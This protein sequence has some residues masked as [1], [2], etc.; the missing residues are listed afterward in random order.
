MD[1]VEWTRSITTPTPLPGWWVTAVT[2][3]VAL[4]VTVS[5][6]IPQVT[7]S[8]RTLYGLTALTTIVHEA[9]H[10][11]TACV[12]GGG[13]YVIRLHTADSGVTWFWFTSWFSSFLTSVAGYAAPPLAGLGAAVLL[14]RGQ[15][16]MVLALTAAVMVVLL[17]VARGLVTVFSV[18]TVGAVAFMALHFAPV[19]VQHWVAYTETW[20]LLLGEAAGLWALVHNRIHAAELSEDYHDD[21]GDLAVTTRVPAVVWIAAWTILLGWVLWK[22]LPLLWP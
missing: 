10:A 1:A 5:A 21:A 19:K 7:R 22:A 8:R 3:I 13:V 4:M 9:G 14:A 18:L 20:L 16:P 12:T 11:T 17:V 6:V 15:A 2:G